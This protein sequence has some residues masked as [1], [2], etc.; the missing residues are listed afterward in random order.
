[1]E[2]EKK[3]IMSVRKLTAEIICYLYINTSEDSKNLKRQDRVF[4]SCSFLKTI[5]SWQAAYM[6]FGLPYD[7][8]H[9]LYAVLAIHKL[10]DTHTLSLLAHGS[11]NKVCILHS[12]VA[13][14]VV[15]SNKCIQKECFH[16]SFFEIHTQE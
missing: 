16:C 12:S 3:K 8:Q 14:V 9:T 2:K 11:L 15:I 6:F 4:I 13:F 5:S 7:S 1:M 10:R